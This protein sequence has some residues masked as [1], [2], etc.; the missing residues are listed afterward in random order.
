MKTYVILVRGKHAG[1][2]NQMFATLQTAL[3]SDTYQLAR[4]QWA[5][6]FE[7]L[8]EATLTDAVTMLN[9]QIDRELPQGTKLFLLGKSLGGLIVTEWQRQHQ[10]ANGI[11]YLAGAPLLGSRTTAQEYSTVSMNRAIT[12]GQPRFALAELKNIGCPTIIFQGNADK[13]AGGLLLQNAQNVR[14]VVG[15]PYVEINGADHSF[16]GQQESVSTQVAAW[17][18][19]QIN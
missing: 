1:S 11:V 6:R 13:T 12:Y 18:A 16:R 17:L 15:W 14:D 7:D 4:F 5:Q 9:E 19:G 2:A 10:R 3:P 8:G